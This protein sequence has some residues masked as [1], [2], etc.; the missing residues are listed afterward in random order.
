MIV[1]ATKQNG[2]WLIGTFHEAEY[3]A[4]RGSSESGPTSNPAK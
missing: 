1:M 4:P 3:P 2:R